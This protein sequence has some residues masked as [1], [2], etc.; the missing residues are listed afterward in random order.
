MFVLG[1]IIVLLALAVF[2]VFLGGN[3]RMIIDLPSLI[4]IIIPL[5]GVL[6]ATKSFHVF[7]EGMKAIILPKAKISD[8]LR[9]QAVLLFRMLSKATAAISAAG[10]IICLLNI[11]FSLD[12]TD[13]NAINTI[14]SN[15]AAGL[16]TPMYG[17][18]LIAALFEPAFFVLKKRK[19]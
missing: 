17:L 1:F 5:L 4:I 6:F 14:G 12:M 8:K 15:I 10:F 7:Y 18:T 19:Q 16:T 2:S 13:P 3:I 11:L 9:D